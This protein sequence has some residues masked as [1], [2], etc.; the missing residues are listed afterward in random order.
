M[1]S[2]TA[3]LPL[4]SDGKYILQ[5]R[6]NFSG[7]IYPDKI[8]FFG[9]HI[10]P[11]ETAAECVLRETKEEMGLDLRPEDIESVGVFPV[12]DGPKTT[13]DIHFFITRNVSPDNLVLGEGQGFVFLE[14]DAD[15]SGPEFA[16]AC[17]AILQ[18]L[19]RRGLA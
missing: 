19:R 18:D 16:P 10:D 8:S 1:P 9:G 4:A 13:G 12:A 7:I 15:L 5:H 2:W 11:G 3:I 6:D 14:P 17:Q